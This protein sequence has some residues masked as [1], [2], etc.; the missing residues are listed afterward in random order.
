MLSPIVLASVDQQLSGM[1][2]MFC[3]YSAHK[4]AIALLWLLSLGKRD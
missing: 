3:I 4:V 2:K 1:K